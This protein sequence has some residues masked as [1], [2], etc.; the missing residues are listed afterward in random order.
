MST[1]RTTMTRTPLQ[2][3]ALVVGLVFLLIGVLGFIPGI[4]A[5]YDMLQAAGH[6]SGAKLFGVFQVSVL[7]NIIHLL[8]GVAGVLLARTWSGARGFL[9]WGGIIYLVI[10]VYGLVV[11]QASGANFVPINT[12]DNWLHLVLGVG[13]IALGV[14]LSRRRPG[15]LS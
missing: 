3:A 15:P 13:M 5:N 11:D 7:H 14:L 8:F 12:A 10:L 1:T 4:T 2:T 6:E 9:I